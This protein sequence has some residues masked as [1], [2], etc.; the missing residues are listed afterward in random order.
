VV[1]TALASPFK[2]APYDYGEARALADQLGLADPVAIALV[3]RGHRTVEQARTFL[4]AN[5]AHDPERFEG[6][7]AAVEAI[8][9]A[10]AAGSRIT[11]HGDYDVDGMCST[12]ILVGALRRAGAECDWIIPDR[13]TDGYG[14]SSASIEHLRER[15]TGLLITA[16][17][18]IGSA[19]EIETVRAMG[20]AA[21][22]TDHHQP[23]ATLPDCPIV[24]PEVSAYPFTGLCGAAVAHKLV[25]AFER[26]RGLN[27]AADES[28]DLDLVALAT[29]ADLV[30]LVGENRSLARRGLA[31]LRRA[32]RPG[33]R[34]LL[35]ISQVEPERLD[36]GDIAFRIA[37]RLNAAGRR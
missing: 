34:A 13:L 32:R 15:G 16:D 10:I 20:I 33:L 31:E 9:A 29:I 19:A 17:C 24:H 35:A 11:V 22:V 8:E 18:G 37:P 6:I 7:G 21:V 1:G 25:A 30:P 12:A 4:D 23:G 2:A 27:D 26:S 3:R 28:R 5:E 36:E 14:L